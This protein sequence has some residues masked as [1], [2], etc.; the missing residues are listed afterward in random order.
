MEIAVEILVGGGAA[1]GQALVLATPISFWGGID[2]GSGIISDPRHPQAGETVAGRI[3]FLPGTIGSSS[4]SSV[5]L[6]LVRIARAPSALI[7]HQPDAIL[8]MGL[9]VAR[10][11][12]WQPPLAARLDRRHFAAFRNRLVEISETGRLRTLQAA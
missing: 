11:M 6:E 12:G 9:V 3:L 8:L 2:P 5:L 7:V 4:A 10:E 1:R